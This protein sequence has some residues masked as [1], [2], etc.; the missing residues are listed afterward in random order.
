MKQLEKSHLPQS[1]DM[2]RGFSPFILLTR[3]LAR[4]I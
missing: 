1:V 4:L 3:S 2:I